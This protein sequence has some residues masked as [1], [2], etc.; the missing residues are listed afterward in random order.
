MIVFIFHFFYHRLPFLDSLIHILITF[1]EFI[2]TIYPYIEKESAVND[3]KKIML[4]NKNGKIL[5][6]CYWNLF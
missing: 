6:I 2:C 3:D 5:K 4:Y 1:S